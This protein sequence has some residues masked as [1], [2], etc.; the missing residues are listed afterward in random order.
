MI[1]IR[2]T[3]AVPCLASS[4]LSALLVVAGS[5]CFT[6]SLGLGAN[7]HRTHLPRKDSRCNSTT[8]TKFGDESTIY[9]F[10]I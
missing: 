2:F 4:K 8:S 10:K 9:S 5:C 7:D 6:E 3:E 1:P